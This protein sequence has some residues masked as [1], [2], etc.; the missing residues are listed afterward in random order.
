MT[1]LELAT[2]NTDYELEKKLE[3]KHNGNWI[4]IFTVSE[5]V[6]RY[7]LCEIIYF[8]NT[9]VSLIGERLS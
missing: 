1:M 4:G 7:G 6:Y 8:N 9:K 2:R 5:L 3:V